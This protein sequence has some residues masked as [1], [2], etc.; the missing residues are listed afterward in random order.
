MK[1]A[2]AQTFFSGKLCKF[3][4]EVVGARQQGDGN[5]RMLRPSVAER[6]PLVKVKLNINTTPAPT[7]K[8]ALKSQKN[9]FLLFCI[10]QY[11][12][13]LFISLAAPHPKSGTNCMFIE[14]DS[15]QRESSN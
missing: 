8:T 4:P 9:H 6:C 2:H 3:L 7:V 12:R 13:R 10:H 1:T 11:G 14:I 5:A 15:A